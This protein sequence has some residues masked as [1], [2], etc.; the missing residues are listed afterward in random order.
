MD[1][2]WDKAQTYWTAQSRGRYRKR[3]GILSNPE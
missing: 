3:K 1:F 2:Y